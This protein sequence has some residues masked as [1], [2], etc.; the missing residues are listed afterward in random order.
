MI[1]AEDSALLRQGLVR[2]LEDCGVDV[3]GESGEADDALLALVEAERPDAVLLDIRMPPTHTDEGVRAAEAILACCPGTGVLLLSQY[4]ETSA[5]V[6][7]L[8]RSP[9]GFGYLLKDRVADADELFDALRRVV[10]GESAVDPDIVT[11]LLRRRRVDSALDGLTSREHQVLA[12]MAEGRS[13]EAISRRLQVSAKTLETHIRSVFAKLGLE[14]DL[15]ANRRVLA[16]LTYLR[17]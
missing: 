10:A 8:A 16:V 12:L 11:R 17:A 13:N 1:V 7:V 6:Q 4:V 2:L 3:V 9:R 5:A 14:P 15:A